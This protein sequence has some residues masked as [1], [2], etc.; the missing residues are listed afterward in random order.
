MEM[1]YKHPFFQAICMFFAEF[2]CLGVY[3]IVEWRMNKVYGGADMNP[4]IIE[5]RQKGQKTNINVML[6]AIPA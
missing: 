4:E 6:I 1:K 5:A 3:K 2:C